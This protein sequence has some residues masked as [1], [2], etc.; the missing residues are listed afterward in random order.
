MEQEPIVS[1]YHLVFLYQGPGELPGEDY[2]FLT[3]NEAVAYR[4]WYAEKFNASQS[5]WIIREL[6][7]KKWKIKND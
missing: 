5:L 7:I 3:E 6:R 4:K 1:V 2:V